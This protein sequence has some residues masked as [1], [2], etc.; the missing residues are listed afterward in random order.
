[1]ATP[2]EDENTQAIAENTQA[3]A[4]LELALIHERSRA[5]A[6]ESESVQYAADRVA[7]IEQKLLET[8]ADLQAYIDLAASKAV[9]YLGQKPTVS[10]LPIVGNHNGDMWDVAE[11]GHNYI[12]NGDSWDD[13][14]GLVDTEGLVQ[15]ADFDAHLSDVT[16][17]V[18]HVTSAERAL[19][20]SGFSLQLGS[21]ESVPYGS[22]LEI[23]NTGENAR[24]AVF[25]FRIPVGKPFEYTDFTA[26]QLA[27]LKGPQGDIGPAPRISI[28]T[29]SIGTDSTNASAEVV[30]GSIPGTY[31]LNL[32]LP[33]GPVGRE[34]R[35]SDFTAEQ[36]AA[37]KGEKGDAV[38]DVQVGTVYTTSP[39]AGA[40][41]SV[42]PA[43]SGSRV[44]LNF[45][46]PR[47]YSPYIYAQQTQTLAPGEPATVSVE[48]QQDGDRSYCYLKFGIPAGDPGYIKLTTL[49]SDSGVYQLLDDTCN[50]INLATDED[51]ISVRVPYEYR[52]SG[53][54]AGAHEFTMVISAPTDWSPPN[55]ILT[56][57]WKKRSSSDVCVF[58]LFDNG[59]LST[60]DLIGG[61]YLVVHFVEMFDGH[62][63][64]SSKE[65][66][67][68]VVVEDI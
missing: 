21:Y 16:S 29:V 18:S 43:S 33:P 55:G 3:I 50:L 56:I 60:S 59:A 24:N 1:M 62:Y 17:A 35:Y 38:K 11:N 9:R 25:N 51:E 19:W 12:W 20:T 15:R 40:S 13:C 42:D 57:H 47:G 36:L 64:V 31:L 27:A 2:I 39:S 67:R 68:A 52:S 54:I 46:I 65:L 44:I 4:D 63:M 49:A 58:H 61:G 14:T 48:T 23:T 34:F 22:G 26:E 8:T 10:D 32:V 66:S 53:R 41:V 6:A 7:Y 37:L 45:R 30:S 28:G 5:I